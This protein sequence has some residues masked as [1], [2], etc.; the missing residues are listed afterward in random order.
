[1]ARVAVRVKIYGKVQGVFFRVSMKE[2]ADLLKVDGWVRNNP[3]GSV[4]SFIV[5]EESQVRELVEWCKRGPPLA[6]VTKIE[7]WNEEPVLEK[8]GFHIIK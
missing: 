5:G 8:R 4:E 3:D 7:T 1:M 6:R 2:M